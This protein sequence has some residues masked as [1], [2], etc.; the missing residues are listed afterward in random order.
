MTPRAVEGD[1]LAQIRAA[2][3][4]AREHGVTSGA[5]FSDVTRLLKII[6]ANDAEI[7][8]LRKTNEFLHKF[9]EDTL[10]DCPGDD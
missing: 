3:A 6:E 4:E 9:R 10:R 7:A 1:Y 5:W 8:R 2:L